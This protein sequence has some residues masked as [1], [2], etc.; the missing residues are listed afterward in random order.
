MKIKLIGSNSQ[1]L[2]HT[3]VNEGDDLS[4]LN[5]EMVLTDTLLTKGTHSCPVIGGDW[6]FP[7]NVSKALGYDIN[8]SLEVQFFVSK[9]F[10]LDWRSQTVLSI[11]LNTLMR[12]GRGAECE[13]GLASRYIHESPLVNLFN[14]K[15]LELSLNQL[16]YSGWVS[17]SLNL[18]MGKD[19]PF[20]I[21]KVETGFPNY[22]WL[23]ILEGVKSKASNWFSGEE[24]SL[25][26]SWTTNLVFSRF[27]YPFTLNSKR[28]FVKGLNPQILK[29]FH[30][31]PTTNT[32]KSSTFTESTLIGI[33]T[34]WALTLSESSRRTIRP[35]RS[36][37]VN[38]C[39]F[40]DDLTSFVS[41]VFHQIRGRGLAD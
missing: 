14:S 13:S 41:Q 12:E 34:S 16:N 19:S 18:L 38:Q 11:P 23:S 25:R 8:D 2:K 26:E 35:L 29:H 7:S 30:L 33:S 1:L 28:C 15:G 6:T 22:G 39:Q 5:P 31:F 40:R 17:I 20:S 36:I 9:W 3:L 37:E 32:Y 21:V 24:E 4:S 10:D 27:P